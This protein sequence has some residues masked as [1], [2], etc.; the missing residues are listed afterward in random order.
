MPAAPQ[1]N[2]IYFGWNI[3]WKASSPGNIAPFS[4]P[5]YWKCSDVCFPRIHAYW[6]PHVP[7]LKSWLQNPTGWYEN[8]PPFTKSG[9]VEFLNMA[10]HPREILRRSLSP[11]CFPGSHRCS[12]MLPHHSLSL[13]RQRA[14][15]MEGAG[16]GQAFPNISNAC[17]IDFPSG[18]WKLHSI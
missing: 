16:A 11:W 2:V 10:I 9:E 3:N 12:L 18:S 5:F 15:V 13:R 7:K 4:A 14:R 1:P 8:L 6:I 17:S